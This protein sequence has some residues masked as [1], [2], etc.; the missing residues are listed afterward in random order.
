MNYPNGDSY[1][2]LWQAGKKH[3]QG[4]Y[5]YSNGTVYKGSFVNGKKQG[6]G[7]I[8]FPNGTKVEAYWNQTH[9]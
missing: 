9:I 7:T 8:T 6:L 2:G 5:R 3:G 1:S 4:T